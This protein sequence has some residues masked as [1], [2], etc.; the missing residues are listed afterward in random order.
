MTLSKTL[1]CEKESRYITYVLIGDKI[2]CKIYYFKNLDVI[3]KG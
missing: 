2:P 3:V 1:M